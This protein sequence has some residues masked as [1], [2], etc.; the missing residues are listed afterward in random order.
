MTIKYSIRTAQHADIS[1]ILAL[2]ADEVEAG[3]ML[4]RDKE[5]MKEGLQDWRVAVEDD[6][7]VGCVSLVFFNEV[8]CEIRSLAVAEDH[9]K[10]GLGK[11]LVESALE[12]AKERGAKEVLTLSRAAG[13]F[14]RCGFQ[15]DDIHNF[16][17]KVQQDCQHCPFIDCC[18]EVA[19]L[20]TIKGSV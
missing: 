6:T 18:D 13:L 9:R 7:I 4:P 2:F 20:F 1:A 11:K 10:N 19:L 8:F 16:P 3:R 14:E 15:V 12:L 5:K 17:N